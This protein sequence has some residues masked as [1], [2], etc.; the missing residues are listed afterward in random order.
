MTAEI[1]DQRLAAQIQTRELERA[2][3]AKGKASTSSAPDA[4]EEVEAL[5]KELAKEK[6]QRIT[7]Q[8]GHSHG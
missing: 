4:S 8:E 3:R 1:E 2:R 6:E 5:K 7:S